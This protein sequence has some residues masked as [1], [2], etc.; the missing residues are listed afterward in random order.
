[1]PTNTRGGGNGTVPPPSNSGI[2]W[3]SPSDLVGQ[4]DNIL[5]RLANLEIAVARLAGMNVEASQASDIVESLG[6]MHDFELLAGEGWPGD[7]NFTGVA[8]SSLGW[9]MSD[10]NQFPVV[11]MQDGHLVYG[12]Q[13]DGSV[14]Y[15]DNIGGAGKEYGIISKGTATPSVAVAN[16][17]IVSANS[18]NQ[19]SGTGIAQFTATQ[20]GLY[21]AGAGGH[22]I[23]VVG[24][25]NDWN[26]TL[27][28]GSFPAIYNSRNIGNTATF[29]SWRNGIGVIGLFPLPA[30]GTIKAE[31]TVTLGTLS[32]SNMYA[33]ACRIVG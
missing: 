25:S 1:M 8:I 10:G 31:F 29:A 5:T 33:W 11:T 4:P 27:S 15:G 21:L 28:S 6:T 23:Y 22:S 2:C 32:A 20:P 26:V 24:S 18:L 7:G 9:T 16:G 30:G 3:A 12:W 19:A 17:M 14:S 13:T